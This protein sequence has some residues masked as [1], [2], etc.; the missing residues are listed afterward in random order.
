[1][2][3]EFKIQLDGNG[4][5]NVVPAQANPNPGSP[6]QKVLQ[7]A[8]PNNP[9]AAPPPPAN[10]AANSQK[11][12]GDPPTDSTGTGPPSS[13]GSGMVFVIGP[14][15]VCGSGSG[16]SAGAFARPGGDPPTD[17]TATGKPTQ[18]Q[19]AAPNDKAAAQA[20]DK[21]AQRRKMA[22]PEDQGGG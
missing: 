11:G 1:M 12:A 17:S 15:V 3:I 8:F 10:P 4:V 20:P 18:A 22:N 19:A 21:P 9:A 5:A 7:A 14:I 16:H 13:S 2:L 6:P